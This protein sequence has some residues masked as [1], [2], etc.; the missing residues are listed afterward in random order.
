MIR[1][2]PRSTLFPYTTLFRSQG[3]LPHVVSQTP[4][5]AAPLLESCPPHHVALSRR[6]PRSTPQ[7]GVSAESGPTRPPLQ[8]L[9]Q[10]HH[11]SY[12]APLLCHPFVGV[13]HQHPRHSSP[14]RPWQSAHHRPLY[15]CHHGH[16][17]LDP[18]PAGFAAHPST[19]LTG[20]ALCPN[21]F[22]RSLK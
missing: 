20:G 15:P 5:P 7:P 19:L 17:R 1:R 12:L 2:P 3:S 10:A 22:W 21:P 13:R 16:P 11:R 14:A 8:R 18:Q 6:S 4:G 9:E